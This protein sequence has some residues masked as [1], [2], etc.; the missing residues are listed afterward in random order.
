MKKVGGVSILK[1]KS[2]RKMMIARRVVR[3]RRVV[4][5]DTQRVRAK[6]MKDLEDL[7]DLAASLA[8]GEFRTQSEGG[9]PVKVTLNQRREW[10]RVAAYI[11]QIIRSIAE[12]F[13]E[14]EID[15][16]LAELGRLVDEAR[17][18][19]SGKTEALGRA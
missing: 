12:G 17:A 8:K 18:K 2:S 1:A 7:F 3:L 6:T 15:E 4:R 9:V 13:D 10:A 14:R 19:A 11:A 16:Q 5:V